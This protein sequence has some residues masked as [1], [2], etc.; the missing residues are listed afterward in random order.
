M[1]GVAALGTADYSEDL[2]KGTAGTTCLALATPTSVTARSYPFGGIS[3]LARRWV[4]NRAID[5][6]RRY[7]L[8]LNGTPPSGGRNRLQTA[9]C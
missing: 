8:E 3:E 4:A 6:L 1:L 5:L 2:Y 7:V 9:L